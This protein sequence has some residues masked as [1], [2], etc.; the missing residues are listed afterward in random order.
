MGSHGTHSDT[1][2]PGN[3]SMYLYNNRHVPSNKQPH[4]LVHQK[5][6]AGGY[7]TLKKGCDEN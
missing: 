6:N 2:L 4:F 5:K 3:N 7:Q 1:S